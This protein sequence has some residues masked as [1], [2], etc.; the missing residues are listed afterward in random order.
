MKSLLIVSLAAS[1]A[2][3]GQEI[4]PQILIDGQAVEGSPAVAVRAAPGVQFGGGAIHFVGAQPIGGEPVRGAPYS[5]EAVTETTQVLADG[6]RI[7]QRRSAMQYRDGLG[8]ERREEGLPGA[9][10]VIVSDPVAGANFT[11]NPQ[12][13][14]VLRMPGQIGHN[15][16]ISIDIRNAVGA[17]P[18]NAGTISVNPRMILPGQ[19]PSDGVT[20]EQLGSQTIEGVMAEGTRVTHAIPAGQIGNQQPIRIVEEKWFSPELRITVMTRH[21]DPRDGETVFKLTNLVRAEPDP[22]LFEVPPDY[23]V[24]E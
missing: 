16:V 13:H 3:L 12:D 22:S 23:K 20:T 1:A 8:R 9:K 15:G 24:R 18:A 17:V 10:V 14:T 5:A 19:P 2:L 11:L 21:S 6:N 4:R 7:E